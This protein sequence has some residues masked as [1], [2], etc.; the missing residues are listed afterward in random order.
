MA[1]TNITDLPTSRAIYTPTE[2]TTFSALTAGE[3]T[4]YTFAT[5]PRQFR[6]G[7]ANVYFPSGLPGGVTA[8]Q[9]QIT[10]AA[11]TGWTATFYLHNSTAG[12]LTPSAQ[13][14]V[15]YQQG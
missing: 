10:G 8:S 5:I 11:S 15:I 14:V 6:P 12:S 13:Q 1:R 2:T 7:S 9:V 3:T 4:T